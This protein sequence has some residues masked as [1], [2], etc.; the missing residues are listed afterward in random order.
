MLSF[1]NW[2]PGFGVLPILELRFVI[3][4]Q[5]VF[6]AEAFRPRINETFLW[7]AKVIFVVTLAADKRAHLLARRLLVNVVILNALRSFVSAHAFN[8]RGP[9][10]AQ[11]HRLRVMTIDTRDWM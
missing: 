5:D 10:D 9:R 6:D 8:E 11:L 7:P 1:Q 3:E 2:R 4:R